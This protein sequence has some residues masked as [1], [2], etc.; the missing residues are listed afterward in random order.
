LRGLLRPHRKAR[1]HL[2]DVS[3]AAKNTVKLYH[4]CHSLNQCCE[5]R[6]AFPR[7]FEFDVLFL[8][9]ISSPFTHNYLK[10]H[11]GGIRDACS[12]QKVP[13]R[14]DA[15]DNAL[16]FDVVSGRACLY[17]R[18]ATSMQRRRVSSLRLRDSG[19][20]TCHGLHDQEQIAAQPRVSRSVQTR[21]GR[22]RDAGQ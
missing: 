7:L 1:R 20:R 3:N 21:P 16:G 17:S 19:R 9:A 18:A 14:L 5:S 4:L 8:L 12:L 6:S 22:F 15:G 11:F 2:R 13:A 10:Q